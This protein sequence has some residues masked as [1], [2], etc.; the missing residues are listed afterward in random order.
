MKNRIRYLLLAVVL[1]VLQ[2]GFSV[3]L[4]Q[5]A[6]VQNLQENSEESEAFR[7]MKISLYNLEQIRKFS[8]ENGME[9]SECLAV[10]MAVHD[11]ELVER[12]ALDRNKIMRLKKLLEEK[13][14]EAY[15]NLI[16]AYEK[17]F[18]DL[19]C[20]PLPGSKNQGGKK[21][22]FFED[23]Y[24]GVRTYG[25]AR[26]HEGIDLFG[27]S[28]AD[29]YYPVVSMTDGVVEKIGWLPLGGYRI[30]IRSPGGGYFYYAHL[31]SYEQEFEVG[32][33]VRAGE[34]LGL[35]GDTGYGPEGTKG[36]FPVHLHLGI[37]IS[38]SHREEMSVNPYPVLLLL[39][40]RIEEYQ[41]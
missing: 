41:Y 37:Y 31:A 20:F 28:E 4:L 5:E 24:G 23:G 9:F 25:G 22:F 34:V 36:R 21:Q 32:D 6:A 27:T 14:P 15:Q 1:A 12:A 19:R 39:E 7:D 17:I 10:L 16:A 38:T 35:M 29:G 26:T 3:R 11:F 40:N 30:G 18:A 33:R 13:K 8:A 2:S